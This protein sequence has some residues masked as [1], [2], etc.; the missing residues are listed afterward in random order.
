MCSSTRTLVETKYAEDR[1]PSGS[2]P[3][4]LPAA[5]DDGLVEPGQEVRDPRKPARP[6]ARPRC[7]ATYARRSSRA[8]QAD[9][10]WEPG[11]HWKLR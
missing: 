8:T 6:G 11:P 5:G 4:G 10:D 3:V 7:E 1:G 2:F 9:L